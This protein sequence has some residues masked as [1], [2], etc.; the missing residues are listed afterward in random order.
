M[1]VSSYMYK[2]HLAIDIDGE[3]LARV[4]GVIPD[5]LILHKTFKVPTHLLV[6]VWNPA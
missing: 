4:E 6:G 1:Y 5:V 3:L 2:T